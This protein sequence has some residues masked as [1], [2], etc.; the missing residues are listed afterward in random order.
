MEAALTIYLEDQFRNQGDDVDLRPDDDLVE[1]GL[2]SIAYVRLVAFIKKTYGIAVPDD[3]LTL[4]NF[5]TIERIVGY[6]HAV[7]SDAG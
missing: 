7:Q 5:G 2:D 4:D 3:A 6:L 1:L